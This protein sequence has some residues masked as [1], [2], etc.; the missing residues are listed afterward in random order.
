MGKQIEYIVSEKETLSPQMKGLKDNFT[1]YI[2]KK[3]S[4]KGADICNIVRIQLIFYGSL[5]QYLA[6]VKRWINT[7]ANEKRYAFK[8]G[9]NKKDSSDIDLGAIVAIEGFEEGIKY[10]TQMPEI[11]DRKGFEVYINGI[12]R[13]CDLMVSVGDE[14]HSLNKDLVGYIAKNGNRLRHVWKKDHKKRWSMNKYTGMIKR[15]SCI[16]EGDEGYTIRKKGSILFENM[17]NKIINDNL[18][19]ESRYHGTS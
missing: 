14:E 7:E 15:G 6:G 19:I 2:I 11:M 12:E 5:G 3:L 10:S 16:I 8:T 9:T 17:E 18:D 4:G 1:K 13:R